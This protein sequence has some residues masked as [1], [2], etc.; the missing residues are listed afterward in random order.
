MKC[1]TG[2]LERSRGVVWLWLYGCGLHLLGIC[3]IHAAPGWLARSYI[4]WFAID[5]LMGLLLQLA[6]AVDLLL[7]FLSTDTQVP[8]AT[9]AHAY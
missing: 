9:I 3:V 7:L 1:C 2:G 6:A 4:V 5:L 8:F